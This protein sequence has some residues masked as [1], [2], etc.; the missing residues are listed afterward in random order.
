[1]INT[2]SNKKKIEIKAYTIGE[3]ADLYGVSRKAFRGW[4]SHHKSA[5]GDRYGHYYNVNQVKAIFM[6]LGLPSDFE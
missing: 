2:S 4:L 5:I 3:L 6:A 1:M